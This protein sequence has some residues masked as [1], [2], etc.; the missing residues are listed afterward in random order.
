MGP[1]STRSLSQ[2][3]QNRSPLP[4]HSTLM[5]DLIH[6]PQFDTLL[7]EVRSA[8]LGQPDARRFAPFP[9]DITPQPVTAMQRPCAAHFMD[10]PVAPDSPYLAL[11]SAMKDASPHMSWRA[12]YEGTDIGDD[13]MERFGCFCIVGNNA[14]FASAALWAFMTYMPPGLDY[15]RHH[16]PAEELY[17]I[18]SGRAD[19]MRDG[20][21]P[22]TLEA[23]S[24][25]YHASNQPHAMRTTDQPALCLVF[26]RNHFGTPPV[27][28]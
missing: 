7:D 10:G 27:L 12:T 25:V 16:H 11:H 19:F 26:W 6:P 28:S 1:K 15:P 22:E 23:G 18:V 14:P 24:C 13:F 17:L 20:A 3:V 4:D 8:Y 2:S 9:D 21:A 5:S